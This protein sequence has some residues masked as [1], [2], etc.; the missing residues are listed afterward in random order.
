VETISQ[1]S[2]YSD[3][4]LLSL[5]KVGDK[6]AFT[7]I[8]NRFHKPIYRYLIG[9]V[10]MEEQAEDL[11]HEVFLKLWESREKLSIKGA[12]TPY[13]F[14]VCH[15]KAI[16]AIRKIAY[17]RKLRAGLLKA[18]ENWVAAPQHS[19]EELHRFDNL[20]E[21]SLDAL[22]PQRRKVYELCRING[23]TY[24]EAASEMGISPN[25]VKDHMSKALSTLRQIVQN[26]G[27]LTI[28]LILLGNIL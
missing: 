18:Y 4:E 11:V 22:S 10:K 17:D 1:Y 2:A 20:V 12:F 14:R 8:Y 5:L 21:E 23:K 19:P 9:M 16:D 28:L 27:E 7:E 24:N 15:N 26:R 25:T 3:T 13:L 6:L